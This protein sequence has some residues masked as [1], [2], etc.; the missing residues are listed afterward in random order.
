MNEIKKF[1]ESLRSVNRTINYLTRVFLAERGL[2]MS[3]FRV[4]LHLDTGQGINMS[5]LQTH[6]LLASAT[7]TGLVDSL[8]GDG[9][10]VRWRDD[11]DR[12]MVYLRLTEAGAAVREEVLEF[13]R[14]CLSDALVEI[15]ADLDR[16]SEIL[17]VV[18]AGLKKQIVQSVISCRPAE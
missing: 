1:E 10:V 8:V 3:R 14:C 5:R 17:T 4:L 11:E 16:V 15:P 6:M 18:H 13:R 12:R 7:I 9:L 2:S